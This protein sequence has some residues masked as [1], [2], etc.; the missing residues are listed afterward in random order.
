MEASLITRTACRVTQRS[1]K[2][3]NERE[4]PEPACAIIDHISRMEPLYIDLMKG[5]LTRYVCPDTYKPI[6]RSIVRQKNPLLGLLY[7]PLYSLLD[8]FGLRL[9]KYGFDAEAR[10]WGKD[11]PSEAETMVGLKR[12]EN[13]QFCVEDVLKNGVAG[14]FVETGVWRG[15]VC[16]LPRPRRG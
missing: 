1:P 8:H 5:V 4:A 14:D 7:D 9:C 13:V 3:R 2:S 11:W 12:L 15:G 10:E 6:H 16:I